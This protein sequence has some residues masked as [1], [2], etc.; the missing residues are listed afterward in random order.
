MRD[1]RSR[2]GAAC[3]S[4]L[5]SA[6]VLPLASGCINPSLYNSETSNLYPL[7]PGDQPFVLVEVINDTTAVVDYTITVDDGRATPTQYPFSDI[8]PA[9]RDAGVLVPYPFLRVNLGD[10]DN[11]I[12]PSI[13]AT[14]PDGLTIQV[15]PQ[16]ASLRAGVDFQQG[17]T[18]IYRLVADARSPSAITVS[19]AKIEG[20]TQT[21]P[22]TRADTFQVVKLLLLSQGLTTANTN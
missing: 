17:D 2:M 13:T 16:V 12:T 20:T 19:V 9:T 4:G 5:V 10:L 11:P 22:F 6:L 18:I 1:A 14:L 7:A 15:P 8:T 21:G 3:W